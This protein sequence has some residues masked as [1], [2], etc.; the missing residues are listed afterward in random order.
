MAHWFVLPK[1]FKI[2]SSIAIQQVRGIYGAISRDE[3]MFQ[4]NRRRV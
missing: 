2:E 1:I 3:R 4:S